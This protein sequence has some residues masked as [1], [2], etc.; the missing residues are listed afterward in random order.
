MFE[1]DTL[2]TDGIDVDN[3]LKTPDGLPVQIA[4]EPT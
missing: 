3:R 2:V 4:V 1:L